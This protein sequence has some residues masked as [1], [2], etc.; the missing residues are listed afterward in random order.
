MLHLQELLLML[1]FKSNLS[2]R[3]INA[4]ITK[5]VNLKKYLKIQNK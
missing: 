3:M 2:I 1:P 4:I 5:I